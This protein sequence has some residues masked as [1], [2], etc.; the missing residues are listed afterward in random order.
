MLSFEKREAAELFDKKFFLVNSTLK[1]ARLSFEL[2]TIKLFEKFYFS[3]PAFK[4]AKLS[5]EEP[6]LQ[7]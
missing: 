4:A 6:C 5:L 3:N 2:E 7:V 1:A